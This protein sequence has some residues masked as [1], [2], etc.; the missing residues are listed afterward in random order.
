[1]SF[2]AQCVIDPSP[3]IIS[4]FNNCVFFLQSNDK[5]GPKWDELHGYDQKM[6]KFLKKGKGTFRVA[7]LQ[8]NGKINFFI[9]TGILCV[10]CSIKCFLKLFLQNDK[11]FMETNL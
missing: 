8:L 11:S 6:M 3:R 1:M 9:Q 5:Q 7:S 4:L 10:A 2:V